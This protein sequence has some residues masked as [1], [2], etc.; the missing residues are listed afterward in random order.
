MIGTEV[1]STVTT[2]GIYTNDTVNGYVAS[3]DII[4]TSGLPDPVTWARRRKSAD[5]YT[6]RPWASGA[7]NWTGFDYRGEPTPRL[8]LYQLTFRA[9]GY[10]RFSE[11]FILLLPGHWT[12]KPVLHAV[13]RTG[14]GPT[15]GGTVNVWAYGNCQAVELFVQLASAKEGRRSTCNA[16]CVDVAYASERFQAIGYNNNLPVITNTVVTTGTPAAIALVPDRIRFWRMAGTC[17]LVAV[18]VLDA[19]GNVVPIAANNISFSI[20]ARDHWCGQWQSQFARSG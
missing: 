20:T 17:S 19:Q 4:T 13:S 1:G 12:L 18:E 15:T 6:A 10:M 3:Y 9:D 11:G 16:C 7:F 14:I 2:R 5:I 8:A